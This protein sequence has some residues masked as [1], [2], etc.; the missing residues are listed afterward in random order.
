[1]AK[2]AKV[3]KT[4]RI[5]EDVYDI[6]IRRADEMKCSQGEYINRLVRNREGETMG[7]EDIVSRTHK[8]VLYMDTAIQIA[9]EMLNMMCFNL[10][11]K[12][13]FD[14][15][16]VR[17]EIYNSSYKIVKERKRKARLKKSEQIY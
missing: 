6:I 9:V 13:T 14:D 15:D 8:S 3:K 17:T 5:D 1:M 2:A 11:C 16:K 4:F 12:N 10:N 7:L